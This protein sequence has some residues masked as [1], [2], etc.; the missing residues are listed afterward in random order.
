MNLPVATQAV[1]EELSRMRSEGI[2][3]VFI[4]DETLGILEDL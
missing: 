2:S 1:L 4:Q 3:R